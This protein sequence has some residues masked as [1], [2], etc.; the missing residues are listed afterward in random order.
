MADQ[1]ISALASGNPAALGDLVVIARSGNNF[2]LTLAQ[3]LALMSST[4]FWGGVQTVNFA[5]V[6]STGYC[7]GASALTAT[8]P[9]SPTVGDFFGPF[10]PDTDARVT[11]TLGRNGNNVN[12][13]AQDYV[14]GTNRFVLFAQYVGGAT[15]YRVF[16]EESNVKA[17]ATISGSPNGLTLDLRG[18]LVT[19]FTM[20]LNANVEQL[21]YLNPP[22]SGVP[23]RGEIEFTADGTQRTFP[24]DQALMRWP[25]G[26]VPTPTATVNKKDRYSIESS[27]G[28]ANVHWGVIALG[29]AS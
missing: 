15:G 3:V 26:A 18:G 4:L 9:A 17:A 22:P 10:Y 21:Y 19:K 2:Q 12:G 14:T 6:K 16:G 1:K 25:G 24:A 13:L 20:T 27:D 8:L 7:V 11:L 23:Y 29:Y 28:F 5:V